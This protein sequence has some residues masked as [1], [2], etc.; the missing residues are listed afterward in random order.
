MLAYLRQVD[1]HH[2]GKFVNGYLSGAYFF[3]I[4]P[5]LGKLLLALSA[6]RRLRRRADLGEDR[7]ADRRRCRCRAARA[8]GA[9]GQRAVPLARG[10][11]RDGRLDGGQPDPGVR[12][13]LRRVLPRRVAAHP[14]TRPL[15]GFA[16]QLWGCAASDAHPPLKRV[17]RARAAGVG[18]ALA[19]CTKWTGLAT[20][21][22]AGL[23]CS[24]ARARRRRG[25]RAR[26]ER[27]LAR[28]LLAHVVAPSLSS[29]CP[30]RHTSSA[31]TSTLR[32][33]RTRAMARAS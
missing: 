18:I 9:A 6:G 17:G 1:E 2:F 27:L 8:V 21:A 15:L 13:A 23:H 25:W 29:R 5:P 12:R 7:H 10:G 16:L 28:P 26:R 24:G 22:T 31:S 20:L 30:P 11:A 14:P 4:H 33:C 3:D 19:A 32:C